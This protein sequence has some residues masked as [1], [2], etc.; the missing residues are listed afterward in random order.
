MNAFFQG[1]W[2][3]LVQTIAIVAGLAYTA[4]SFRKD[5]EGH[6]IG[7]LLEIVKGYREVWVYI[8]EKPELARI[9]D[10]KVNF[11]QTPITPAED[12]IVRLSIQHIYTAYVSSKRWLKKY[13]PEIGNDVAD[14]LSRPI[15]KKVWHDVKALQSKDFVA[16]VEKNLDKKLP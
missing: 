16:F 10:R 15:P 7:N 1:N 13:L 14:Y 4:L 8:I 12:R 9:F 11:D 3:E 5:S 2:L 6:R